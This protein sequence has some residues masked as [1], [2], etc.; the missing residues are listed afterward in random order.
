MEA[1]ID[2]IE[3]LLVSFFNVHIGDGS[4]PS[5]P[6]NNQ[7]PHSRQTTHRASS[8]PIRSAL[9]FRP[10]GERQAAPT[11]TPPQLV[12]ALFAVQSRMAAVGYSHAPRPT[13]STAMRAQ[14]MGAAI[15]P[16]PEAE[17]TQ[18]HPASALSQAHERP[19]QRPLPFPLV[20][21]NQASPGVPLHHPHPAAPTNPSHLM[22]LVDARPS[23][24]SPPQPNRALP[25]PHAPSPTWQSCVPA[26]SSMLRPRSGKMSKIRPKRVRADVLDFRV[27]YSYFI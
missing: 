10:T 12:P 7:P 5:N 27:C 22:M 19:I 24:D 6:G 9:G 14:P 3:G 18:L 4:G 15:S 26:E 21:V 16:D 11:A 2:R 17:P 13:S 20:G 23:S 1:K 25:T 8:A